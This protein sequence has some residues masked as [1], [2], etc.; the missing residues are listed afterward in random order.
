[1]SDPGEP[2]IFIIANSIFPYGYDAVKILALPDRAKYRAR[3]DQYFVSEQIRSDFHILQNRRGHYCFRDYETGLIIPLR[4][5]T[6]DEIYLVGSV[7]Y[8]GYS[9]GEMY[10]FPQDRDRLDKQ[11]KDFNDT[12]R[13]NVSLG[14]DAP[15]KDLYP[16]VLMSTTPV[17]FFDEVETVKKEYDRQIRR[18]AS[19]V[20]RLSEFKYFKY[21]PFPRIVG[22]RPLNR[23][24]FRAVINDMKLIGATD[25][26]IQLIHMLKSDSAVPHSINEQRTDRDEQFKDNTSYSIVVHTEP[27]V[28]SLQRPIARMTGSYDIHTFVFRTADISSQIPAHISVDYIDRSQRL[29]R[30][31][32]SLNFLVRVSPSVTFPVLSIVALITFFAVYM[33]PNIL[34]TLLQESGVPAGV[35]QDL[36]IIAISLTAFDVIGRLNRYIESRK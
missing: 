7:Y 11:V 35:L 24:K 13:K 14:N 9:V 2:T 19:I 12:F 29:A 20:R 15:G 34:P 22:M 25:Y 23:G 18:W 16:L 31:D 21:I 26:E 4:N 17:R 27:A 1:M 32:T 30:L 36:S 5:I 3:F 28:L 8:I 6:I 33:A 10:D